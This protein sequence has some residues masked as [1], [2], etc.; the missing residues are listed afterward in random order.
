M[1]MRNIF[2]AFSR[3][4]KGLCI[5]SVL[6]YKSDVE[7]NMFKHLS[8]PGSATEGEI[9]TKNMIFNLKNNQ[10]LDIKDSLTQCMRASWE[11]SFYSNVNII[12]KL[13]LFFF[14]PNILNVNVLNL[15][16]CKQLMV[17]STEAWEM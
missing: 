12:K 5:V 16:C 7:S 9:Q 17:K 1:S 2:K 8:E 11:F 6:N 13:K 3:V 14:F 4:F 15:C 10:I